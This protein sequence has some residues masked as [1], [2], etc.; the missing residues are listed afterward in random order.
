[1]VRSLVRA[2]N[3]S[4]R[5]HVFHENRSE[6]ARPSEVL[7]SHKAILLLF[8]W[9]ISLLL[10]GCQFTLLEEQALSDKSAIQVE[11]KSGSD[12][13]VSTEME[14]SLQT[15]GIKIPLNRSPVDRSLTAT[16]IFDEISPA[17]AFVET[18]SASGSGVWV[19][20][21]YL[22]SNAHVVWPYEKV[23]R[24]VFPNGEEH[25]DVPVVAWDLMADL[26]LL[27]PIDTEVVPTWFADGSDLQIG[28]D[29]F[30]IGYPGEMEEYPQPTLTQGVL[31]R[32]RKWE[33]IDLSF[34]QVDAA[35]AAGQSGGLLATGNGDIVGI[36]TFSFTEAGFGLVA[37]AGDFVQ[38]LERLLG[39]IDDPSIISRKVTDG[40]GKKQEL[41]LLAD[42]TDFRHYLLEP[43]EEDG[44]EIEITIAGRR[45]PNLYIS[46]LAGYGF[47]ETDVGETV[48]T[49]K[50]KAER[51]V[52]YLVQIWHDIPIHGSYELES[53][54]PLFKLDD[55]DDDERL[56]VDTTF[57]GAIDHPDDVDT[58]E[59]DLDEGELIEIEVDSLSIDPY[60]SLSYESFRKAATY[61]DDDSGG[62][63]FGTNS[64]LVFKAPE[65]G[66]YSIH[67]SPDYFGAYTGGY[68]LTI[69]TATDES[70]MP[71]PVSERWFTAS[72][73][74]KLERYLS[75]DKDF[76]ILFPANWHRSYDCG[77]V[78][79]CF[80]SGGLSLVIQE[81]DLSEIGISDMSLE[82]YVETTI[83]NNN[84]RGLQFEVESLET[85]TNTQG[86]AS[87]MLTF[88]IRNG[89]YKGM[90]MIHVKDGTHVFSATFAIEAKFFDG[91]EDL[92]Q[93]MFDSFRVRNRTWSQDD[94]IELLDEG[95]SFLGKQEFES[96]V[97]AFT[98]AIEID[99]Y[100]IDAYVARAEAHKELGKKHEAIADL[101]SV[102]AQQAGR[103][104][105][106]YSKGL[107]HY[108]LEDYEASLE[109]INRAIRSKP[110]NTDYYVGRALVHAAQDNLN[111][112]Q[113]D[114]QTS[115]RISGEAI[116]NEL[117]DVRGYLYLLEQD[118]ESANADY[119]R[120]LGNGARTPS[121]L[122][123]A[124]I[125]SDA[126]GEFED[127]TDLLN[128]GL[129]LLP[130]K[131]L[132]NL[133]PHLVNL[134][135]QA[136]ALLDNETSP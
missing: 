43:V 27:G 31:S 4:T 41:V 53:S 64:R 32:V 84:S 115:L 54:S 99:P 24:V 108:M 56:S 21:G 103:H 17:V 125:A 106:R 36:S 111:L 50:F 116:T 131:E 33:A 110:Y 68:F 39:S 86:I 97:D 46:P 96:A 75:V 20:P 67:V 19:E 130:E 113:L 90:R 49:A 2:A 16:E 122:L 119:S 91:L 7:G 126:L 38:R 70:E 51:G 22:I 133:A 85:Q 15:A 136:E 26:A 87:E 34:F 129:A 105:L 47:I 55:P 134:K 8:V 14:E 6:F 118:F 81:E 95:N 107:L 63:I 10:T 93:Y 76:E 18:T 28:N 74:G 1:M 61:E 57:V 121:V 60:L 109:E 13:A 79:A 82:E 66:R 120:A 104:E 94:V 5:R 25:I 11:P 52:P 40:N 48:S 92:Y 12:G 112:A 3:A 71:D 102:L 69:N 37:S 127:A 135:A 58:F 44:T 77:Q 88:T 101:K 117:L 128:E 83:D 98:Q 35:I 23:N 132:E 62:G 72:T 78:T 73:F 45:G 9:V 100:Q 42:D 123:G 29:I 59:I 80:T 114:L 124:G 89:R 65:K 30:L